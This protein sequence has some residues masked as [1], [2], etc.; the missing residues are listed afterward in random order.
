MRS[1]RSILSPVTL[2]PVILAVA[3]ASQAQVPK[4]PWAS[5]GAAAKPANRSSD[6]P[7]DPASDSTIKVNVKLVNVFVSVTDE[8][9]APVAGLAKENF[10]LKEDDKTQNISVFEK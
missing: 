9:G 7:K 6:T 5:G 10:E 4:P 2:A 8:H 3:T 1:I